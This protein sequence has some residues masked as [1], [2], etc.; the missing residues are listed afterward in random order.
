MI[1]LT[2]PLFF[3]FTLPLKSYLGAC[4]SQEW[5]WHLRDLRYLPV[6][7]PLCR[8]IGTNIDTNIVLEIDKRWLCSCCFTK[9]YATLP[10]FCRFSLWT[11]LRDLI[12]LMV[13]IFEIV[14][15]IEAFHCFYVFFV[16]WKWT[17]LSPCLKSIDFTQRHILKVHKI[18][19]F[20]GFDFEIC[21][22]SLLVMWKY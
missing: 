5:I 8:Y 10:V 11:V 6:P 7:H 15:L 14:N 2:P 22:I 18:E 20:F 1:P 12:R 3:H 21:I 19:I 9:A 13:S 16:T 17:C 4:E